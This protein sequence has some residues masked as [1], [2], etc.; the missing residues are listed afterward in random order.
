MTSE[1]RLLA[2]QANAKASTGPKTKAG[3]ARSANNALQHGLTIPVSN[4]P[5]L[6]PQ[7]EAIAHKIAGHNANPALLEKARRIAEAQVKLNRVRLLRTKAKAAILSETPL[8]IRTVRQVQLLV[9]FLDRVERDTVSPI[10]LEMVDEVLHP[11][12]PGSGDAVAMNLAHRVSEFARLDRY[13]R[14]A[15]SRRKFAIREF[16]ALDVVQSHRTPS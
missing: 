13:E 9:R 16:D 4:D 14:R 2:N 5:A 6:A 10:D 3:K 12:P 8:P 15:L 11:R 7:V 1:R